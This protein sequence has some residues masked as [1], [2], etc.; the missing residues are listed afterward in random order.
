MR[1]I[2]RYT[3]IVAALFAVLLPYSAFAAWSYSQT[4]D[5]MTDGDLVGQDSWATNAFGNSTNFD[6]QGTTVQ[7][8]AKAIT[9]AAT[10]ESYIQRDITSTTAG[11]VSIYIR[12]SNL[13]GPTAELWVMNGTTYL[14][15]VS[16]NTNAPNA[17]Q[18]VLAGASTID[19]GTATANTWHQFTVEL[20]TS[21]D[22]CRA[23]FDGSS[24]TS[25]VNFVS[26]ATVTEI[27]RIVFA[28]QNGNA[29][30]VYWDTIASGDSVAAAT[31][32]PPDFIGLDE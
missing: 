22:Q 13:N 5:G 32:Q 3:G 12:S 23:K 11:V 29:S 28:K 1:R 14:C 15:I 25:W 6:V 21:T 18:P 30:A 17:Q 26:N 20:D 31:P 27:N 9:I 10:A 2:T 16:I 24:Y 4:F 8:G 19:L 7:A